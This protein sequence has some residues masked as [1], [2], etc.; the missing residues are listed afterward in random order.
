MDTIAQAIKGHSLTTLVAFGVKAL[1]WT[2]KISV[3]L[4][5]LVVGWI[6]FLLVKDHNIINLITTTPTGTAMSLSAAITAVVGGCMTGAFTTPDIS[7]YCQSSKHVFWMT[8]TSIVIGEFIVNGIAILI[9]HALNTH[10][11]VTIMGQ[12]AGWIGLLTVI[13]S[14]I[15]INDLNLYSSS[16][17]VAS[18]VEGLTGKKLPYVWLTITLGCIGTILSVLGILEEF[19]TFLTFLGILFPPIIGVM[20]IDYYI[21]HTNRK[22]LDSSRQTGELPSL[23]SIPLVGWNA[24]ISCLLGS[25]VGATTDVGIPSLNSLLSA[26]ITYWILCTFF[27]KK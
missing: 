7:R 11:V 8:L 10:D 20:L 3:P 24:I 16:L 13:L 9:A 12:T 5:S 17:G 23:T 19:V 25:V 22:I 26:S 2:A 14:A 18:A 1:N 4:F 6:F 21:I 27:Q 15:K